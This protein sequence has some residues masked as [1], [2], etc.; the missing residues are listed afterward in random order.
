M[1]SYNLENEERKNRT[2]A[3]I[4]TFLINA[5]MLFLFWTITVWSAEE[6]KKKDEVLAGGGFIMNY[7][8][9]KAGSG[10]NYS[11]NK[12]NKSPELV[13]S[14]PAEDV[15]KTKVIPAVVE[16]EISKNKVVPT[17]KEV[18]QPLISSTRA[19]TVK[20]KEVKDTKV[21][22]KEK[23]KPITETK[24]VANKP[25]AQP[26][27]DNSALFPVKKATGS[28]GTAGTN[29]KSGGASDGNSK[30]TGNQGQPEGR[31]V[32]DGE[33]NKR[34]SGDGSGGN[35]GSGGGTGS[36]LTLLGWTWTARPV[37]DDDSNDTGIIKFKITIDSDGDVVDISVTESTVSPNVMRKY[38][39]VLQKTKFRPTTGDR[40]TDYSTGT[41]TFRLNSR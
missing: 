27:I 15:K 36:S 39:S 41:V 6:N 13:D 40:K 23:I 35:G 12:A 21:D 34:P 29:P 18:E 25:A 31:S 28:N 22:K 14:K 17:K 37:V 24:K 38:K 32:S 2:N 10:T 19:S 1:N 8:T 9:D 7:G 5:A 4:L 26:V 30:G 3:F 11:R 20:Y 33:Y 16:P